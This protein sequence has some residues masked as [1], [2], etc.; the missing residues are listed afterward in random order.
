MDSF[1]NA[2][3]STIVAFIFMGYQR[4]AREQVGLLCSAFG[5]SGVAD[6]L[7]KNS[8]TVRLDDPVKRAFYENGCLQETWNLLEL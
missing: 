1:L 4:I 2:V 7:V 3:A 8:G 6:F 5:W